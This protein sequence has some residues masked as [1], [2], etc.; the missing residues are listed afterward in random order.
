MPTIPQLSITTP[1]LTP[2]PNFLGYFERVDSGNI[3]T[4][5]LE[6]FA[7]QSTPDGSDIKA[8]KLWSLGTRTQL[9]LNGKPLEIGQVVT[10]S[11][12]NSGHLQ[13]L[14]DKKEGLENSFGF[15]VQITQDNAS[16]SVKS[17]GLV[18][19]DGSP[20]PTIHTSQAEIRFALNTPNF[21]MTSASIDDKGKIHLTNLLKENQSTQLQSLSLNVQDSKITGAEKTKIQFSGVINSVKILDDNSYLA[22][23]YSKQPEKDESSIQTGMY[24]ARG[25]GSP[26]FN[27]GKP[28]SLSIFS[29]AYGVETLQ[30]SDGKIITIALSHTSAA[31]KF[32][33]LSLVRYQLDGSIDASFR[34]PTLILDLDASRPPIKFAKLQQDN[35]ILVIGTNRI[36]SNSDYVI[37]RLNTDGSEDLSF[38]KQ[39][40][41]SLDFAN[42]EDLPLDIAPLADG[43]FLVFGGSG[44]AYGYNTLNI[45]RFNS[46]GSIDN[47]FQQ[48]GTL[49]ITEALIGNSFS[50][51]SFT[52]LANGKIQILGGLRSQIF[53]DYP[54]FNQNRD[55]ILQLDSS[56]SID[57]QFGK[58]G[59]T[60]L[61]MD[62]YR[63]SNAVLLP[64]LDDKIRIVTQV[65]SETV[66]VVQ[67][68]KDGSYDLKSY[69]PTSSAD[70]PT[71]AVKLLPFA[72]IEQTQET[73]LPP[74]KITVERL[75]GA[76]ASDLFSIASSFSERDATIVWQH[77]PALDI[78][79]N[80]TVARITSY[81][82]K[83]E[84]ET[85][86]NWTKQSL[87][88][89]LQ[90]IQYNYSGTNSKQEIQFNWTLSKLD[91][92]NDIA[93]SF[94]SS[95][96]LA[97]QNNYLP[98]SQNVERTVP[99]SSLVPLK[100]EDFPFNDKDSLDQLKGITISKLLFNTDLILDNQIISNG[101][102][103]SKADLDA[104]RLKII[105]SGGSTLG[106][107]FTV[108]DGKNSSIAYRQTLTTKDFI[109]TDPKVLTI[110]GS[111][112]H[113]E[114]L[115]AEFNPA[116]LAPGT[117][118]SF[119]WKVLDLELPTGPIPEFTP[120]FSA[121]GNAI[122]VTVRY[123]DVSGIQKIYKA[124]SNGLIT[125]GNFQPVVE[126]LLGK[127]LVGGE[128]QFSKISDYDGIE[129]ID[130]MPNL[131]FQWKAD[132]IAIPNATDPNFLIQENMV[133]KVISLDISY[134]DLLGHQEVATISTKFP[135]NKASLFS[136]NELALAN[137]PGDD[138]FIGST[139]FE[140]VKYQE[141]VNKFTVFGTLEKFYV[142]GMDNDHTVDQFQK[143]DRLEFSDLSI[144]VKFVEQARH[145]NQNDLNKL[146]ELYIAFFNR[147]PDAD[148]LSYWL[149]QFQNGASLNSIAESFYQ[150]GILFSNLTG[151]SKE[152]TNTDFI[153]IVYKNTLGRLQGADA[154]GLN[155]WKAQL[156]SGS[157]NHGQ[158]VSTILA[159]AHSFKSDATW[160]WVADL[161][162]NKVR[163]GRI[164]SIDAGISFNSPEESITKG[165]QAVAAVT[166]QSFGDGLKII[167][168]QDV[169]IN[170]NFEVS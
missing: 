12:L 90:N 21:S 18:L 23:G 115:R 76:T 55:F 162:D 63:H 78:G 134:L 153:N 144:N 80:S 116:D 13:I 166:P 117:K 126:P 107:D 61:E 133:G 125:A 94:N 66:R 81:L 148:G 1:S 135:V 170:L 108:S 101:T 48:N 60:Y 15:A 49:K 130:G 8:I 35:K 121:I 95:L 89:L 69:I 103:I 27:S 29:G 3:Y 123:I 2:P 85:N 168:I 67:L 7:N 25:I 145:S 149:T 50:V 109:N 106:F 84:I 156:D 92:P 167:G 68:N 164:A 136:A 169:T 6:D 129:Q 114:V 73:F 47:S 72:W 4:L 98:T 64:S 41:V 75:E 31:S 146:V 154:E 152:M 88:K 161:L 157:T 163:L 104:G 42:Q 141:P 19:T 30:Q 58:Q 118:A 91:A 57:A 124:A 59:I 79:V 142:V 52:T 36:G 110:S 86:G 113:G 5:K 138:S 122:E 87:Q 53:Q 105:T 83:L 147:I 155:Y 128:L 46:D 10:A 131:K 132:G 143:V 70:T 39:G 65:D 14:V 127:K 40:Y 71:E 9:L 28:N 158:L 45:T 120:S 99:K 43:K 112:K 37:A 32:N 20:L 96:V 38:G 74:I 151:F 56:G 119:V 51:Q 111:F 100:A 165:M 34:S 82:G 17:C 150:A 160:G 16:W 93:R 26:N 140:T 137:H 97:P 11:D 159:S 33:N 22:T 139:N 24:D 77:L 102:Y 62:E 44:N 54:N